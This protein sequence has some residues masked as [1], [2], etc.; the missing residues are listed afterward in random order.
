MHVLVCSSRYTR[1]PEAAAKK[2]G[3]SLAGKKALRDNKPQQW[4][5]EGEIVASDLCLWYDEEGPAVL[6]GVSFNIQPGERV[7]VVGRTG[8]GKSSLLAA[9]LRMAPSSGG[10]KIS[11]LSGNLTAYV[12]L[13]ILRLLP[14]LSPRLCPSLYVFAYS[15]VS[16]CVS[17]VFS[18][19]RVCRIRPI[20]SPTTAA[21][22][23]LPRPLLVPLHPRVCLHT[24]PDL[25]S[26]RAAQQRHPSHLAAG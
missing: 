18:R 14:A 25:C 23:E 11:G 1:V 3:L 26:S 24:T 15:H 21:A 17:R 10:L 16:V 6:K 7:G 4:L 22:A 5:N 13:V 12:P 19:A 9:I 20:P 8:A 2:R